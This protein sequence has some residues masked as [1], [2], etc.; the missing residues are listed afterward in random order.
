MIMVSYLP[1]SRRVRDSFMGAAWSIC[2]LARERRDCPATG[3]LPVRGSPRNRQLALRVKKMQPARLG[4]DEYLVTARDFGLRGHARHGDAGGADGG[5]EQ[6]FRAEL[7]DD[8]DA[9][10]EA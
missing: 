4:G 6:N 2:A 7:F 10:I 5:L 9:G 8:Y 1:R 3:A